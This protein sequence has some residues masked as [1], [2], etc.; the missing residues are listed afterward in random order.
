MSL[1]LGLNTGFWA[2]R[3][4]AETTLAAIREAEHLGFD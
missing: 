2:A 4:P 1:K 3:A